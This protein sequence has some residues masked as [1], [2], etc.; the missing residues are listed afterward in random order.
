[1]DDVSAVADTSND[2]ASFLT[3]SQITAAFIFVILFILKNQYR[4]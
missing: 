3:V 1:M 4:N 2:F